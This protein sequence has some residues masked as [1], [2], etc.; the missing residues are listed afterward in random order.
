MSS[1]NGTLMT[2]VTKVRVH[3][4][5]SRQRERCLISFIGFFQIQRD[6]IKNETESESSRN[7]FCG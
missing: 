6:E 4:D 3:D 5:D 1:R 7:F 2:C